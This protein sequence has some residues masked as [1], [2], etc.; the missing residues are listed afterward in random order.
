MCFL[1][2]LFYSFIYFHHINGCKNSQTNNE[3]CC[4]CVKY[5]VLFTVQLCHCITWRAHCL[6]IIQHLHDK[7]ANCGDCG[8]N[9]CW[10]WQVV[11]IILSSYFSNISFLCSPVLSRS[12][13]KTWSVSGCWNITATLNAAMAN[14]LV[15]NMLRWFDLLDCTRC[16]G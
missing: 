14:A 2:L 7:Q 6:Q 11:T 5:L 8:L 3:L 16:T 10:W 9:Y 13:G 1:D 4:W 15:R 12:S